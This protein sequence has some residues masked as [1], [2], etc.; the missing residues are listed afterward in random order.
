MSYKRRL[1][2]SVMH[3]AIITTTIPHRRTGNLSQRGS[4]DNRKYDRT[5]QET[6][7]WLLP[8]V[9]KSVWLKKII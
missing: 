9:R 7:E 1:D 6:A 4:S 3:G 5:S 8:A 2:A